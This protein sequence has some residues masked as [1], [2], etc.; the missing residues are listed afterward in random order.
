LLSIQLLTSCTQA[1]LFPVA[2]NEQDVARAL[3]WL[4]C[5]RSNSSSSS[6]A[7]DWS[8]W[9][10]AERLSLCDVLALADP[11][12]EFTWRRE[13]AATIAADSLTR[14]ST[15]VTAA[16]AATVDAVTSTSS[17]DGTHGDRWFAYVS[18]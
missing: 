17:D 6:T 9:L 12:A 2:T 4:G 11:S 18:H 16:T 13:L 5:T 8:A 7:V 3:Q 1:K 14:D 10:T 15:A